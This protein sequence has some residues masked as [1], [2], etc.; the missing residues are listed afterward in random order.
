LA[1]R[2][3]A[4]TGPEESKLYMYLNFT[5]VPV[6]TYPEPARVALNVRPAAWC[7]LYRDPG[8]QIPNDPDLAID[9]PTFTFPNPQTVEKFRVIVHWAGGDL[10]TV[11]PAIWN[12]SAG[13]WQPFTP[14]DHPE[15]GPAIMNLSIATH[16]FGNPVFKSLFFQSYSSI[17]ELDSVLVTVRP[18]P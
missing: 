3:D 15:L 2:S 11:T 8:W 10:V 7:V 17:P 4:S 14:R 1:F 18:T 13:V 9:P 12:R 16:L 5:D 6:L